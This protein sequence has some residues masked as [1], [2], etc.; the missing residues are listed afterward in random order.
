MVAYRTCLMNK[1]FVK[2]LIVGWLT[3]LSVHGLGEKCEKLYE[4]LSKP[5]STTVEHEPLNERVMSLQATPHPVKSS[6]G[7]DAQRCRTCRKP[8][9]ALP[10]ILTYDP[11]PTLATTQHA[12][13][14][15]G[16]YLAVCSHTVCSLTEFSKSR[17]AL[18]TLLTDSPTHSPHLL[19]I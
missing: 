14:H 5:L 19:P 1:L 17:C 12:L 11:T 13:C 6:D 3:P 7:C 16:L 9:L 2:I 18:A 8:Y 4:P 10:H 15:S